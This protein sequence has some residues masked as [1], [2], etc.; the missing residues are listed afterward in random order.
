MSGFEVHVD[1]GSCMSAGECIFRAPHTFAFGDDGKSS[2]ID[3]NGDPDDAVLLAA[4]ACPN[5]AI[6]VVKDGAKLA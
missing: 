1:R 6:S 2:V 5:F 3:P 4:Q